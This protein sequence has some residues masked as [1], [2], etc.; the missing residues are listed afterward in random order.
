[1]IDYDVLNSCGTTQKRLQQLFTAEPF[2]D[3]TAHTPEEVR[4]NRLDC[5]MRYQIEERLRFRLQEHIQFVVVLVGNRRGV[6]IGRGNLFDRA[7]NALGR[8]L[9]HLE[10]D[11]QA[12]FVAGSFPGEQLRQVWVFGEVQENLVAH[13]AHATP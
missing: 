10:V 9:I 2:Q 13:E 6:V 8:D 1:M 4:N 12:A 11:F 5:D 7:V 3:D